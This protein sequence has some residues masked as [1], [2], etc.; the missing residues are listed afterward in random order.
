MLK[1]A[2]TMVMLNVDLSL[3]AL[4]Y[5][6]EIECIGAIASVPPMR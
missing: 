4:V 1:M 3:T 5:V 6:L 2:N